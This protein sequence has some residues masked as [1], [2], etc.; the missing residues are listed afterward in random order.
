MENKSVQQSFKWFGFIVILAFMFTAVGAVMPTDT[1]A[2]GKT[3]VITYAYPRVISELDPSRVLSSEN[4]IMLNVWGTLTLWDPDKGVIPYVAK[5]WESNADKTVWTFHLHEGIKCHD[6]SKFTAEDVKFSWE[7]TIKIGSLAYVFTMVDSI[8][9]VDELTL[10]VNLK[11]PFR[12][13]ANAG[14]SWGSYLMSRNIADKPKEWF[15]AGNENGIGPYRIESFEPGQRI[16]LAKFEDWFGKFPD[17]AYDKVVIEIVEDPS[18]R[19]Q[20]LRG[21]EAHLAWDISFDD[22]DSLNKSGKVKAFAA[23]AYYQMQ[24]HLNARRAPLTDV[25]VRQALAY[26]FPYDSVA[27]G[28]YGGFGKVAE[29]AVPRL[30]W[31]PTEKTKTYPLDLKKAAELLKDAGVSK[32]TTFRLGVE[33]NNPEFIKA[34]E[35]WQATL[36]QLGMKLIIEKISAGVRW[37]EVYNKE[38]KFDIMQMKMQIGFDSPNEFLGSL[39]HSGWTW[40]PFSGINNAK[41]NELCEQAPS[42]EATDKQKSDQMYQQ[43]EQILFDEAAAIFALD[44]PQDWAVS[45]TV[46]G[47]KAN[48]LYGY[49]VLFFQLYEK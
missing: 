42:F 3:R 6:G 38:T 14:N 28:T 46:G 13:D 43:A 15:A 37:D 9:V 33:V 35:L 40:Y 45:T 21:G 48:P 49:D 26:S 29:G 32:G 19:A 12:M 16:V 7:R 8:E 47:F 23:P 31:N 20:K 18:V 25:R 11:F 41:F 24:W 5:S 2:A 17:N 1:Q 27:I 22:F 30:M 4:N 34:A 10:R 39:F 44:L 36:A